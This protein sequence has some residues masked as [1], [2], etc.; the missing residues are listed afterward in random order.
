MTGHSNTRTRGG[1]LA[2]VYMALARP[3]CAHD[4][5]FCD[6]MITTVHLPESI[7]VVN[8]ALFMKLTA[9]SIIFL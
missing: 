9:R 5:T 8:N 4:S 2:I 6:G 3:L 1:Q 7:M